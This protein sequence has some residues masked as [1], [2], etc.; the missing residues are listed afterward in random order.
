[1]RAVWASHFLGGEEAQDSWKGQSYPSIH[2]P[3]QVP[4]SA[5]LLPGRAKGL[6]CGLETFKRA[7]TG[8]WTMDIAWERER[9]SS[10][11]SWDTPLSLSLS[12]WS[13]GSS[14]QVWSK[15]LFVS[16]M[17]CWVLHCSV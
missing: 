6:G 1:M 2:Q 11:V 4:E 10:G 14:P 8:R 17:N 15:Y 9:A 16:E 3:G 12:T 13:P 7:G 5:C